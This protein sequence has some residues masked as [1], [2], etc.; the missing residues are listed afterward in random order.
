MASLS[1]ISQLVTADARGFVDGMRKGSDAARQFGDA[2]DKNAK[3]AQNALGGMRAGSVGQVS[4]LFG[5]TLSDSLFSATD[6]LRG[7]TS[8]TAAMVAGLG[9]ATAGVSLFLSHLGQ[10]EE[11]ARRTRAGMRQ[12]GGEFESVV[13]QFEAMRSA[14]LLGF[15]VPFE[16]LFR[17]GRALASRTLGG[18]AGQRD[19]ALFQ[20]EVQL[21]RQF[22]AVNAAQQE[23]ERRRESNAVG[24]AGLFR[25]EGSGLTG[26][27][28]ALGL[29]RSL[30]VPDL[31][32]PTI[33][34]AEAFRKLAEQARVAAETF[35][36][37]ADQIR[38]Y[39]LRL[40]GATAEQNRNAESLLRLTALQRAR[41]DFADRQRTFEEQLS[42]LRIGD[43]PRHAESRA[44]FEREIAEA[45]RNGNHALVDELETQREIER[46][47]L[48]MIS[49]TERVNR[50]WDSNR[51]PLES[52]RRSLREMQQ[53]FDAGVLSR[54][55][56][57]R[58]A[59]SAFDLLSRGADA[60]QTRSPAAALRDSAE[61]FSAITRAQN[62]GPSDP[63]DRIR[64]LLERSEARERH[65]A[66]QRARIIH[67]LEAQGEIE[68]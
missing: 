4:K 55:L 25:N 39:E 27:N 16:R 43:D 41:Q 35:G 36:M 14:N 54:D 38:V 42:A 7:M 3:K 29:L 63:L 60:F 1:K 67:A 58:G 18:E 32:S 31:A 6:S 68:L 17:G 28:R 66:D 44:R 45:R 48:D 8:G 12:L 33:R 13:A 47:R 15:N 34:G 20:R 37:T 10:M 51:S 59:A 22:E 5:G 46:S 57:G 62:E 9:L 65:A 23:F 64:M 26:A 24:A 11:K 49:A 53:D 19:D 50:L 2:A 30:S 56:F 52:F 61:A 21:R 40:T